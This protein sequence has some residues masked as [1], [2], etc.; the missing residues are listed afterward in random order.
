M[1]LRCKKCKKVVKHKEKNIIDVTLYE[2]I[3]ISETDSHYGRNDGGDVK[4]SVLY[5]KK[6]FPKELLK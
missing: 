6:C 2:S 5:H 3:E 1:D 4:K